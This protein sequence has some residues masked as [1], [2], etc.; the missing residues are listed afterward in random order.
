MAYGEY[1][2]RFNTII[3]D[4]CDFSHGRPMTKC[5]AI[6][7]DLECRPISKI[8]LIHFLRSPIPACRW[9]IPSVD[10]RVCNT[11]IMYGT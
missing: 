1:R 10:V 5:S 4:F 11:R 9:T 6:S 8:S 3:F 2:V 7:I